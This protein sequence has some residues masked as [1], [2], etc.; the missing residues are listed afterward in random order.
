LRYTNSEYLPRRAHVQWTATLIRLGVVSFV[1][2]IAVGL[3]GTGLQWW[4][5][6]LEPSLPVPARTVIVPQALTLVVEALVAM[7]LWD[8]AIRTARF[9]WKN[10]EPGTMDGWREAWRDL[11]FVAS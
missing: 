1:A 9:I 10:R 6:S 8:G 2:N 4:R 11:G 5:A 3:P 7:G